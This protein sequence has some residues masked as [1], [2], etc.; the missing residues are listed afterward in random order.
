MVLLYPVI[1]NNILGLYNLLQG[2]LKNCKNTDEKRDNKIVKV[3]LPS[4]EFLMGSDPTKFTG[5][6]NF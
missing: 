4:Y 5:T 1:P 6:L 3:K 2:S